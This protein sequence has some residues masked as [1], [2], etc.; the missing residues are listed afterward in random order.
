MSACREPAVLCLGHSLAGNLQQSLSVFKSLGTSLGYRLV[1]FTQASHSL[2]SIS[3]P[4]SPASPSRLPS[5]VCRLVPQTGSRRRGTRQT[6]PCSLVPQTRVPCSLV[7][8]VRDKRP[9]AVSYNL[10]EHNG[11]NSRLTRRTAYHAQSIMPILL[12]SV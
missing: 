2:L 11:F 4:F 10:A 7:D 12:C 8:A 3:P 9:L 5:L 1:A 6:I